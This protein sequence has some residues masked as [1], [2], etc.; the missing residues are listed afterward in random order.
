MKLILLTF[1]ALALTACSKSYDKYVGY[2][3]LE[4]TKYSKILEIKKED[5]ETYLINTDIIKENLLGTKHKDR[6]LEKAGENSLGVNNGLAV[7]PL[8]LSEDGKTLRIDKE[9]YVKIS[10]EDMKK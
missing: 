10:E 2:W 9:K 8:N 6:V 5:K 3:Q 7:I 4:D 1:L